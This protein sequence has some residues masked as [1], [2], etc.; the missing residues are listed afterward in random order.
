MGELSIGKT[1][2]ILQKKLLILHRID[3]AVRGVGSR[4]AKKEIPIK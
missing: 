2:K 4:T 3:K 1:H